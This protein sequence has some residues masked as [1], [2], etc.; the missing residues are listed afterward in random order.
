MPIVGAAVGAFASFK[1]LSSAVDETKQLGS[2][3]SKLSR[4]T[5][6]AP[7]KASQLLF[8]FKHVG[9]GAEDAS[10]S[11]G[12]FS[13]NMFSIQQAEEDGTTASKTTVAALQD[14]GVKAMDA[15][16]NLKP[17]DTLLNETAD[18]FKA[19]PNGIEKTSLAMQLF[20][21]SGKDML[22]LLNLGSAGLAEM[23]KEA[24][25]LGLTLSAKN[26]ASIKAYSAEQ[27]TLNEAIGGVKLQIGLALMPALTLLTEAMVKVLEP[28]RML[29]SLFIEKL[30]QGFSLVSAFVRPVVDQLGFLYKA[31]FVAS[32]YADG[33]AGTF[34]SLYVSLKPV[35]ETLQ[36]FSQGL[37]FSAIGVGALAGAVGLALLPQLL[38][39][40]SAVGGIVQGLVAMGVSMASVLLLA[41]LGAALVVAYQKSDRF[42]QSVRMVTGYVGALFDMFKRG[43]SG[44]SI[45]TVPGTLNDIA[46]AAGVLGRTLHEV[47][48]EVPQLLKLGFQSQDSDLGKGVLSAWQQA[49]LEIGVIAHNLVDILSR[50]RD[51]FDW[52]SVLQATGDTLTG[53]ILPAFAMLTKALADGTLWLNQHREGLMAV[54]AG[55]GLV[56]AAIFPVP[57]LVLAM[58]AAVV[59]VRAHWDELKQTLSDVA[60]SIGQKV[61]EIAILFDIFKTAGTI[62]LGAVREGVNLVISVF[63]AMKPAL[64]ADLSAILAVFNFVFPA[65]STVVLDA[66]NDVRGT[67][68][69][70]LKAIRDILHIALDVMKGDWDTALGDV[71]A[72]VADVFGGIAGTITGQADAA[73]S[74]A[75]HFAYGIGNAIWDA[76]TS[77]VK[78]AL[79]WVG[80]EFKK[81][82][83]ISVSITY[84]NAGPLGNIPT[85]IDVNIPQFATGTPY[86]PQD[87]LAIVHKGEAIIPAAQNNGGSGGLTVYL[88]NNGIMGMAD[89]ENWVARVVRDRALR[90]GFRGVFT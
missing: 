45:E 1:T 36:A 46:H 68:D 40:G 67:F 21:K 42:A 26:L 72:L 62:A 7:E 66:L 30:T 6:L 61:P 85:G 15:S 58:G 17:L 3:V 38:D 83:E 41:A 27:K 79:D 9:L 89:A 39:M 78:A 24:D 43:Y 8:A 5:G 49:A 75:W 31:L 34:D 60:A 32:G 63:D 37:N 80:A 57:A 44:S 52:S 77:T 14:I 4:E 81:L 11:L 74:A 84:T 76:L 87:M 13:K 23:G 18:K 50:V 82:K 53:L 71:R 10:K 56:A 20:G 65:I 33:L 70:G 16:G 64:E 90:G 55:L 69:A 28:T 73:A 86:V 29:V 51:S 54:G 2:E 48:S 35:T 88:V 22:P 47:V 59:G 19:M 25:K 12:I